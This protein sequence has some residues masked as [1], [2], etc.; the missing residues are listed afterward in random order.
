MPANCSSDVEAVIEYV[1]SVL[2]TNDSA[3]I[4][5]VKANFGLQDIVHI[6]DFA[7]ACM[8][9]SP[10]PSAIVSHWYDSEGPSQLLA[11]REHH[12]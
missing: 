5:E 10:L 3:A 7:A 9:Q 8:Y 1:D 11:R 6:D 12:T 4:H 2:Q